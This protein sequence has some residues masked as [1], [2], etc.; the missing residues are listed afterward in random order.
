MK[1]LKMAI[2]HGLVLRASASLA[3]IAISKSQGEQREQK[4]QRH[5]AERR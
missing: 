4:L 3:V 5:N 1:R 2:V